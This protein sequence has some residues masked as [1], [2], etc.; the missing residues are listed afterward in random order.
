MYLLGYLPVKSRRLSPSHRTTVTINF[1]LIISYL[2]D[3][4]TLPKFYKGKQKEHNG[5]ILLAV[6]EIYSP[7][8]TFSHHFYRYRL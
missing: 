1:L 3:N 4:K 6:Y 8:K 2:I 5:E 7:Q